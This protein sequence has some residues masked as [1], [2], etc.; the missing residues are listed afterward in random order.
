MRLR[1]PNLSLAHGTDA[2][3]VKSEQPKAIV[4]AKPRRSATG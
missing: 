4:D 1:T 3:E 2:D